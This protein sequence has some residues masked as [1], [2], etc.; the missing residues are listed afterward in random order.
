MPPLGIFCEVFSPSLNDWYTLFSDPLGLVLLLAS[1]FARLG[2][3]FSAAAAAAPDGWLW[4]LLVV[5]VEATPAAA[6]LPPA[7]GQPPRPSLKPFSLIVGG[8]VDTSELRVWSIEFLLAIGLEV[9]GRAVVLKC[10]YIL[11]GLLCPCREE[12]GR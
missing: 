5:E 2:S 12:R 4:L 9:F 10:L 8:G 3:A 7:K 11:T 1:M 6:P